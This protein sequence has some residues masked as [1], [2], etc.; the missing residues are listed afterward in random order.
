MPRAALLPFNCSSPSPAFSPLHCNQ[1]CSS[2]SSSVRL[3]WKSAFMFSED[4][5][6]TRM[7][8]RK[9]KKAFLSSF[10]RGISLVLQ[11]WRRRGRQSS[12]SLQEEEGKSRIWSVCEQADVPTSPLPALKY[13][14]SLLITHLR[15]TCRTKQNA[16][17][18]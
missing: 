15:H 5:K 16:D 9:E 2:S 4:E 18:I 14:R 13:V 6:R 17:Q 3:K 7:W 10:V 8:R 11:S 1:R 12:P